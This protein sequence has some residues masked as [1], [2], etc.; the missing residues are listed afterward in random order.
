MKIEEI[1]MFQ[2]YFSLKDNEPDARLFASKKLANRHT[3]IAGMVCTYNLHKY[4]VNF[5]YIL[6]SGIEHLAHYLLGSIHFLFS[7]PLT[8]F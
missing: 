6:A 2:N 5:A 3:F 8:Y 4:T 1:A 7:P